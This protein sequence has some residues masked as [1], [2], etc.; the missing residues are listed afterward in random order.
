MLIFRHSFVR[1]FTHLLF[2]VAVVSKSTKAPYVR[3]F[4]RSL[5]QHTLNDMCE[6]MRRFGRN[7]YIKCKC[8]R[9]MVKYWIDLD[10]FFLLAFEIF[11][12]LIDKRLASKQAILSRHPPRS[13][14][15]K[16]P[17]HLHRSQFWNSWF[18]SMMNMEHHKTRA[19]ERTHTKQCH[20]NYM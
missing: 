6:C 20:A 13:L 1:S 5:T 14:E 17:I 9:A 8:G 18:H 11:W 12:M 3:C 15:I 16:K 19:S 4:T 10:P 2:S 7:I